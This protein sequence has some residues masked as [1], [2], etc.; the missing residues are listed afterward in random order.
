MIG[1]IDSQA[2]MLGFAQDFKHVRCEL[3]DML[4]MMLEKEWWC[5][6]KWFVAVDLF[7]CLQAIWMGVNM[8]SQLREKLLKQL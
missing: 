3:E 5:N 8:L 7:P 4:K 1:R 2:L 6:L